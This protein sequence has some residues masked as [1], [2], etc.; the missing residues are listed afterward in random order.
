MAALLTAGLALVFVVTTT[1]VSSQS[2]DRAALE[3]DVAR[4]SFHAQL[5]ERARSAMR[6]AELITQ[7]PVFRAHLTD[8]RLAEDRATV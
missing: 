6:A 7:L 3:L 1:V 8:S 2:R 4:S 5:E